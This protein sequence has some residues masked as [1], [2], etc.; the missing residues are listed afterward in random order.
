MRFQPGQSGNPAGRPPGSLDR[1]TLA[2]E[3]AMADDAEEVVASI[4]NRA[5]N[6]ELA[7]MRVYL[8]RVLPTGRN[9]PLAIE[10]PVIKTPDDAEAALA[11]VTGE[12]AAGNLTIN[13]FSAL[14]A[15][16]DRIVRVAE[17]VWN[18]RR[19]RRYAAA[20]D[21]V[22]LG[23]DG[24]T[25]AV[26]DRQ[27]SQTEAPEAPQTTEKPAAPLY[28]PVNSEVPAEPERAGTGAEREDGGR[29][30][31]APPLPLAA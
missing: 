2:L 12:I 22:L 26:D 23:S 8:D 13:E 1:K 25:A 3:A 18:F 9:R 31:T 21:A 11:E 14:I 24:E 5:K 29:E 30:S 20:H 6:G 15:P 7:A 16:V 17:R 4:S 28:S 27:T 19:S 10:L